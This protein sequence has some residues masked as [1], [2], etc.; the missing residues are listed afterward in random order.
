MPYILNKTNGTILTT[1]DDASLDNTTS[2]TFVGRNY[3]G[4]GEIVNENF[5][6]LLENF[7]NSTPPARPITGQLW[8]DTT[9]EDRGLK[10]CYNGTEFKKLAP[11]SVQSSAPTSSNIGDLWWN[12]NKEELSVYNGFRNVVINQSTSGKSYWISNDEKTEGGTLD[13]SILK[14]ETNGEPFVTVARLSSG[15]DTLIPTSDSNL[16]LNFSN[17]VR[18]GITLPGCD[19]NGSSKDNQYYFWGTSA[20]SL[21]CTTATVSKES[22]VQSTALSGNGYLTFVSG[23]TSGNKELCINNNIAYDFSTNVLLTTSLSSLYA[24]LA[25]RYEADSDY[26]EGTVV[27]IGGDKEVTVTS[28]RANT[29]VIGIVSKNP[30]YRMNT[31]AG[32]DSTHPYIALKGRV[33]CKVT[34]KIQK[35]DLLVTS[36][37]PGHATSWADGDSSNAVI[38]KALQD[39]IK[40]TNIIEVL[41]V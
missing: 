11:L 38:G 29:A 16:F 21:T 2:L 1:L 6:K 22:L 17:G 14:A 26:E 32:P 40:E 15:L 23:N 10:F 33:P 27:I 24:D 4:Y 25:E 41:V 30:A 37:V 8:F 3:S 12:P 5:L 39:N 19:E 7:A 36:E 13:Y 34:G 35:G 18:K 20:E 9:E 28:T 31:N